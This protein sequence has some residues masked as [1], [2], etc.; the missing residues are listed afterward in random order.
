MCSLHSQPHAHNAAHAR[1]AVKHTRQTH[2]YSPAHT[3]IPL[4]LQMG[5]A[6]VPSLLASPDVSMVLRVAAP[7]FPPLPPLLLL[8]PVRVLLAWDWGEAVSR[9]LFM[10]GMSSLGGRTTRLNLILFEPSSPPR[11][12]R[13]KRGPVWRGPLLLSRSFCTNCLVPS[14]MSLLRSG[15]FSSSST[16]VP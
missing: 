7:A 3:C 13:K 11:I 5:W 4:I 10:S 16:K 8:V 2:T 14:R 1:A 12:S 15:V 9:T 6:A